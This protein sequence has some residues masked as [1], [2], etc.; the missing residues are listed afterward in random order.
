MAE[1]GRNL[2]D[3]SRNGVRECPE[4]CDV[5]RGER[6]DIVSITIY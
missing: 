5:V 6:K 4:K 1:L 2:D 3:V